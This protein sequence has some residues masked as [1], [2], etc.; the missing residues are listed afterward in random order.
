LFYDFKTRSYKQVP[1]PV[2][3]VSLKSEARKGKVIKAN[4]GASLVDL[5]DSVACVEFHSKMN[6]IGE[7][8][9]QVVDLGL[10]NSR[11]IMMRW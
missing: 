10:K 4:T 5:G 7:D 2:K 1:T 9:L 3:L 6:A 8:I 11:A